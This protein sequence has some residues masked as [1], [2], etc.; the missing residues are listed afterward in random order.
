[1]L[2]IVVPMAGLGSRFAEAGYQDPKPLI[3]VHGIPMIEV[4]INN[5]RLDVPPFCIHLPGA[6][7]ATVRHRDFPAVVG[8][9]VRSDPARRRDRG[10]PAPCSP[11]SPSSTLA[12]R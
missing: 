7:R 8:A 4:V 5:L 3:P 2:S 11:P 12:S 1:M 10:R 9:D 6:A